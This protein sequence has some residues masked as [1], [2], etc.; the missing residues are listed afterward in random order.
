MRKKWY[1]HLKGV[2]RCEL[3]WY[4][5]LQQKRCSLNK[6]GNQYSFSQYLLNFMKNFRKY[7]NK[8]RRLNL[9]I[10]NRIQIA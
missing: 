4:G 9:N 6:T 5:E 3:L 10:D 7:T 2:R 8:L 1:K